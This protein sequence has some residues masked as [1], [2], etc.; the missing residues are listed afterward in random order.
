[1]TSPN[2]SDDYK[3][4]I[5]PLRES[6][7]KIINQAPWALLTHRQPISII[8]DGI[9][10]IIARCTSTCFTLGFSEKCLS[11]APNCYRVAVKP[12]I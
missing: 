8:N 7:G 6:T 11:L 9:N 4:N 12:F 5:A 3:S 1:M 10:S 2:E